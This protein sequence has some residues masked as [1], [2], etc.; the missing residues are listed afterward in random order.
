MRIEVESLT[1]RGKPF[2]LTYAQGELSLEDEHARLAAD[3]RVWGRADRRRDEV[4][5]RGEIQTA[6][7]L[8]CD[9]CLAPAPVPVNVEFAALFGRPDEEAA[10]A[11]ELR[12]ED[13]D[14]SA[15]E[16]DAIDLDAVVREQILLALP[17][18]QLCR[19]ECKGLC[20][21]CGADLN[22]QPCECPPGDTDPRWAALKELKN[23]E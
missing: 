4:R 3:A 17:L 10:E 14:F 5:V 15:Y 1:E 18:R 22:T 23:S 13:L 16:G 7:E 21:A 19:D 9:R 6:V 8:L 2:D 12:D 11:K 20:P